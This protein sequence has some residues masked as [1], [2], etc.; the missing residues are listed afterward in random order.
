[1]AAELWKGCYDALRDAN[2]DPASGALVY[3]YAAGTSTAITVYSDSELSTPRTQPVTANAAGRFPPIYLPY[4]SYRVK[5]TDAAGV[6]IFDFDGVANPQPPD[7]GGGGGVVVTA[8]QLP[9]TGDFIWRPGPAIT[10]T[11]WVRS[12]ARTIGSASSGASE[13]ANAD[14]ENAYKYL[15]DNFTD[16]ECPV[17]GGRGASASADWAAN[18]PIG[19][20]DMRGYGIAGL[21]T[22]GNSAANRLQVST[23]IT[24]TLSTAA[25]TVASATGLAVGMF[26]NASTIPAGT[27]I[28][29]ISGTTVTL[30]TGTGVTAGSGTAVRF[31]FFPDAEVAG[32]KAGSP[33]TVMTSAEL[34]PHTHTGTVAITGSASTFGYVTG[35]Q[36]F[37]D[38]YTS[39]TTANV[40]VAPGGT[41]VGSV[42]SNTLPVT[43]SVVNFVSNTASVSASGSVTGS[44]SFTTASTGS[45][46]PL[47]TL[48]PTRL[49]THYMKL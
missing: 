33:S 24:T 30:S 43:T 34:L 45:G 48:Q 23:T 19:T 47:R 14:C 49:G 16:A 32:A 35:S 39:I 3:F 25:A 38:V 15:W 22:M 37:N 10:R 21:D 26:A 36:A 11:G 8:D 17:S 28:A 2:D 12:N 29:A 46:L 4:V 9:L 13:R 5:V 41:N 18:K 40:G 7:A 6:T 20:L 27:T 31:S 44:G 1:M 42:T